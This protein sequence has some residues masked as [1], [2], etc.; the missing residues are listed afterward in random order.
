MAVPPRSNAQ[1][2]LVLELAPALLVAPLQVGH[3]LRRQPPRF[4]HLRN[5]SMAAQPPCASARRHCDGLW[6]FGGAR[7]SLHGDG[8]RTRA[9]PISCA[10]TIRASASPF[11]R[12]TRS[13]ASAMT[14]ETRASTA[15][16]ASS[17]PPALAGDSGKSEATENSGVRLPP[18]GGVP[19]GFSLSPVLDPRGMLLARLASCHTHS[20]HTGEHHHLGQ[21]VA[22]VPTLPTHLQQLYLEFKIIRFE[23]RP[24]GKWRRIRDLGLGLRNLGKQLHKSVKKQANRYFCAGGQPHSICWRSAYIG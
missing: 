9:A 10:R 8:A 21:N 11:V 1:P 14:A 20:P 22:V 5:G 15:S 18:R 23:H 7:A 3:R 24:L 2:K 6:Q 19:A 17:P 4:C 12:A 16:S 13:A